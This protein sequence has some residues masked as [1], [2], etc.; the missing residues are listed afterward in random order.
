MR[1]ESFLLN[2]TKDTVEQSRTCDH[3]A[4]VVMNKPLNM[5]NQ[6]NLVFHIE[7]NCKFFNKEKRR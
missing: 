1:F 7:V 2:E 5:L 3:Y 4:F 6:E